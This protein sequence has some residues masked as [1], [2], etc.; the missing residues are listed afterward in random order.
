MTKIPSKPPNQSCEFCF[1]TRF[2]LA[3]GMKYFGTGQ[4]WRSISGFPQ[5]YIYNTF[6][7][8]YKIINSKQVKSNIT[9]NS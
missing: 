2:G 8:P 6:L 9:N 3:I 4:Y 7:L 5:K 1:G